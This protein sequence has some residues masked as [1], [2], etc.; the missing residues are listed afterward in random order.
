M[1]LSAYS[2]MMKSTPQEQLFQFKKQV[3]QWAQ[4]HGIKPAVRKWGL[5]RNTIRRWQR[6]FE[7][8]GNK[9]LYDKRKGPKSIPHKTPSSVEKE[10]VS[11]R[12]QAPCYGPRRLKYFFGLKCSTGAIFRILKE[13]GLVKKKRKKHQIKNDLREVKA[14]YKALGHLQMDVKYLRD[15]PNYWGQMKQLQLPRFQYT[16]RDTKSG[17]LFLGF[18]DE[19]SELTARTMA[20]YML[21]RLRAQMAD[22]EIIVQTDNGVEFS[23]TVRHFEKSTFSQQVE[24]Y[25]AK[26]VFIPPKLCNANGDVESIHNTIE[27]EFY[28]L[29]TFR[30]R[31][32]FMHKAETYRLFYNLERP[33]SYKAMK[34]PWLITQQDWPDQDIASHATAIKAVD[35]DKISCYNIRG[36]TL[37][38]YSEKK[39]K[40][41]QEMERI[42]ICC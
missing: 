18:S 6:R 16:I 31:L 21:S 10:V 22:H 13:H 36:P 20:D 14:K 19:L 26:H 42:P 4:S 23:G 17:M 37:P 38:D 35:L 5:G 30:S 24:K 7:K 2:I 25:Q 3:V 1:G 15:I 39:S 9:G 11:A 12:Q 33:N 32:D 41:E 8:E 29:T 34:T 27:K 40:K 28:D